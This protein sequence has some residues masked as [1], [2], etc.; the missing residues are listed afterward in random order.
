MEQVELAALH[1]RA[2][3]AL[4]R[5]P[6]VVGVG[7]GLKEKD[8]KITGEVAFRV[9]VKKKKSEGE[10]KPEEVIPAEFEGFPTDV[11]LIH[12]AEP[13]HCQDMSRHDPLIGGISI[14]NFRGGQAAVAGTLGFFATANDVAAPKNVVLVS[15]NHVLTTHGGN[16]GDVIYQP[17]FV[18][19][20]DGTIPMDARPSQKNPIGTIHKTG[21]QGDHPYTYAGEPTG[22]SYYLDCATALLDISISSWCNTNCGVSYKN[23]IRGLAIMPAPPA[24][25]VAN[26][27]IEDVARISHE[28]VLT[29]APTLVNVHKVGRTT[30]KTTGVVVDVAAPQGS[31]GVG[32]V[33]IIASLK[34]DCDGIMRFADQ[35]DSGAPV[36]DDQNRLVGLIYAIS[37]V[38]TQQVHVSLIH[39]VLDYLKIT[40]ITALNPPV[41]PAGQARA[42]L[43]GGFAAGACEV[44]P[45]RE[46]LRSTDKGA[47]IYSRILD[48]RDEVVTLVN[49]C[50]PVTVAWHR[51]KGPA[52]MNRAVNNLRKSDEPIPHRIE[53][54][55]RAALLRAMAEALRRHGS[56]S[57][58]AAVNQYEEE[59]IA[60]VDTFDDLRE[61][62]DRFER[63]A[64]AEEEVPCGAG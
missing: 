2:E 30:S 10:L 13:L 36:I 52:F 43:Q 37:T 9:Y 48:H 50:R 26:S 23:E 28:T 58:V 47:E 19:R 5:Y 49:R 39:P 51:G 57:L 15:N 45:L 3:A 60:L 44:S 8:G 46:R 33:L 16:V 20:P 27:R 35:G 40:A 6:G 42:D 34:V 59:I 54:V 38:N 12:E 11:L 63:E 29:A 56:E 53:G 32:K 17:R 1:R 18:E 24:R 62:A 7:F 64:R 61:L 21:M 41:G 14:T 4:K 25:Q 55:S 22:D 31:S